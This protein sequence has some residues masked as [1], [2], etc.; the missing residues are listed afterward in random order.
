MP[1]RFLGQRVDADHRD[2]VLNWDAID[3]EAPVG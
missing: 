1:W 2:G 3:A